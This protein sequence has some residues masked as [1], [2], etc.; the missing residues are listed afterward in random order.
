LPSESGTGYEPGALLAILTTRQRFVVEELGRGQSVESIAERLGCHRST[1]HR[2]RVAA[3]RR[4]WDSDRG[5]LSCGAILPRGSSRRRFFCPG[6][7]CR[8]RFWRAERKNAPPAE[9]T[10]DSPSREPAE[11]EEQTR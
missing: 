4:V 5:C 6:G 2:L 9:G 3:R 11:P 8:A 1:V 10:A 7:A